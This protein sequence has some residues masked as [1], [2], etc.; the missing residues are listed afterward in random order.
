ML[1]ILKKARR[2]AKGLCHMEVYQRLFQVF[3][4]SCAEN[5]DLSLVFRSYVLYG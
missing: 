3:F 2:N 1:Y 4:I 5:R